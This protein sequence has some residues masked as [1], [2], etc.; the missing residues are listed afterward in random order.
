MALIWKSHSNAI[1]IMGSS[2][3][4]LLGIKLGKQMTALVPY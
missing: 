3:V 2:Y 1:L 4:A